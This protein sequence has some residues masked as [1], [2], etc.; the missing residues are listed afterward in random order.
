M[1]NIMLDLET[2]G[3]RAGCGILSIGAVFFDPHTGDIRDEFYAVINRKS[4]LSKG[5][6]ED[7]GTL[8]WW[9]QQSAAARKVLAEAETSPKGL[10][11]ALVEFQGYLQ[12]YGKRDLYVWGNGSEFD[13]TIMAE[14]YR[15]CSIPLPWQFW[16]NRCF[17]TLKG[18]SGIPYSTPRGVAHNAL[19]DAK[20]QAEAAIRMLK[21]LGLA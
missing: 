10:G 12:K 11:G 2:L 14:G 18:L 16:N 8:A 1:P 21:K 17:R 7:E 6:H 3:N 9:S 4:C 20:G 5:L 19:D 15:V 13:N